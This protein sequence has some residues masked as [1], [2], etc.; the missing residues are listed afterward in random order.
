MSRPMHSAMGVDQFVRVT[1]GLVVRKLIATP[2]GKGAV[3]VM[4]M[5]RADGLLNIPSVSEGIGA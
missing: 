1:L 4:S 2:S 5:V 3:S